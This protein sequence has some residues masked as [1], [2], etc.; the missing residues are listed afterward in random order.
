MRIWQKVYKLRKQLGCFHPS[1]AVHKS[2]IILCRRDVRKPQLGREF[3]ELI[4]SLRPQ[5]GINLLDEDFVSYLSF[6]FRDSRLLHLLFH[7]ILK[8]PKIE[9]AKQKKDW[10]LRM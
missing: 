5:K 2:L 1:K 4:E 6:F 10:Y 7:L 3:L 8:N 9:R